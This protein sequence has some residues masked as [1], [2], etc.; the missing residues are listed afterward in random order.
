MYRVNC[1]YVY[2]KRKIDNNIVIIIHKLNKINIKEKK[3]VSPDIEFV[4]KKN[5]FQK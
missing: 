3:T 1:P 2:V 5:D 4:Q